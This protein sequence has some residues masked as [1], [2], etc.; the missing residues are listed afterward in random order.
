MEI[1]DTEPN[2]PNDEQFRSDRK[3]NQLFA[4]FSKQSIEV[5]NLIKS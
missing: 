2:N 1:E 4:I 5:L 3:S